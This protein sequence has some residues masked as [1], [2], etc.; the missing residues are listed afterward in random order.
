MHIHEAWAKGGPDR[1][2]LG[3]MLKEAGFKKDL[4]RDRSVLVG[5][6]LYYI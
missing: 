6:H 1:A 3:E 5:L 4:E 2:R